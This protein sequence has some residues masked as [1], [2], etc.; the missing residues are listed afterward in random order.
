MCLYKKFF[1]Y[2]YFLKNFRQ[3]F[4]KIFVLTY[5]VLIQNSVYFGPVRY[6]TNVSDYVC[7]AIIYFIF[8]LWCY[9]HVLP[10]II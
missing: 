8:M 1:I 5:L 6:Y 2:T 4:S 3:G 7:S 9:I 10:F